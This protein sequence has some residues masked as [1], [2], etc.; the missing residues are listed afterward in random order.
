MDT[1][2]PKNIQYNANVAQIEEEIGRFLSGKEAAQLAVYMKEMGQMSPCLYCYV[3]SKRR[4]LKTYFTNFLQYRRD[5]FKAADKAGKADFDELK[6]KMYGYDAKKDQLTSGATKKLNQ[7]IAEWEA[8]KAAGRKHA[9]LSQRV[10]RKAKEGTREKAVHEDALRYAKSVTGANVEE[11]YSEY[12]GQYWDH[13]K[14]KLDLAEAMGGLRGFSLSDFKVDHAIDLIQMM[15]DWSAMGRKAHFYTKQPEFAQIFGGIGIKINMSTAMNADG[16]MDTTWG[17]DWNVV[18][19]LR[20]KYPDVGGMFMATSIDQIKWAMEQDWIGL[21]IPFHR[22]GMPSKLFK[23]MGWTDFESQQ[24]ER[25]YNKAQLAEAGV[26]KRTF[27]AVHKV[28]QYTYTAE[29]GTVVPGHGNDKATYLKLLKKYHLNPKFYKLKF[30]DGSLVIDHPGYMKLVTEFARSDTP[31]NAVDSSKIDFDAFNEIFNGWV[32]QEGYKRESKPDPGTVKSF[33]DFYAGQDRD[34]GEFPEEVAAL[35]ELTEKPTSHQ[36]IARPKKSAPE[37]SVTDQTVAEVTAASKVDTTAPT[38]PASATHARMEEIRERT[39]IGQVWTHEKVSDIDNQNAAI[40]L[41]L[42]KIEKM[43]QVAGEI[44]AQPDVLVH[45]NIRPAVLVAGFRLAIAEFELEHA[46][47]QEMIDNATNQSDIRLLGA[48]INRLEEDMDL[49]MLANEFYGSEQGL[50]FRQRAVGMGKD[51]SLKG[52][53]RRAKGIVGEDV[54][55]ATKK[56]FEQIHA[57][58]EKAN[59]RIKKLETSLKE[60]KAVRALKTGAKKAARM[61]PKTRKASI[62]ELAAK[63]NEMIEKGCIN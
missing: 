28:Q 49:V 15:M 26:E 9:S 55:G 30:A 19:K 17:A 5:I 43:V 61:Q 38:Y 7:F 45:S 63:V 35:K 56:V 2:C 58:L 53:L 54:T 31:H 60:R 4:E 16:T 25:P 22:S 47:L 48:E 32:R 24:N 1:I 27:E 37:S 14:K 51:Y 29:D 42:N 12:G 13:S 10:L 36:L 21:I 59:L 6:S 41:G 52:I 3:D 44:F 34:Y 50:A 39:G 20:K 23:S 33:I 11:G 40:R 18:K 62:A 8:D 57:K 46:A